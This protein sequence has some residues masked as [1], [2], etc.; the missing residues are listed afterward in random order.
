MLKSEFEL[1]FEKVSTLSTALPVVI[2]AAGNSS[3]MKGTDKQEL[4]LFGIPVLARTLKAFEQSASISEI[5]VV[6][7]EDKIQ[8]IYELAKKYGIAKLSAVVSGGA[9]REESVKN[10]LEAICEKYKK[11]LIHDGARPLVST[12]V[13]SRVALSLETEECVICGIKVKDTIKKINK[14]SFAEQT[15]DR[16]EL[17]SVQTPQGVNIAEFLKAAKN[18]TLDKFTDD[19]SLFEAVGHKVKIVEGEQKN[20]KITTPEDVFLAEAYLREESK[21]EY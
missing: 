12:D 9:S 20:I 10:G 3:R 11:A 1:E 21:N 8:K 2:V 5:V 15:L 14:E 13:I 7:R 19:A 16:E 6:T 18:L 4:L 17:I